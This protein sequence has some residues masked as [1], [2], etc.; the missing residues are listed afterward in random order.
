MSL[1]C[2]SFSGLL[3]CVIALIL[4]LIIDVFFVAILYV[5]C[6]YI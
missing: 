6:C 5:Q 4:I 3:W 2:F 1:V